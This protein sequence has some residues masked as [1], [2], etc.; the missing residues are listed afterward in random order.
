MVMERSTK[1]WR[2]IF[3]QAQR[4]AKK[5]AKIKKR[6]EQLNYNKHTFKILPNFIECYAR[7]RFNLTLKNA[8]GY[9]GVDKEG[10]RYQIKYTIKIKGKDGK[11]KFTHALDNIKPS[12]FDFLIAVI[13][14]EDYEIIE[15]YKIPKEFVKTYTTKEGSFRIT[16]KDVYDRLSKYK[17][18]I[19]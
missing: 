5:F 9:D 7:D 1:N 15:T 18:P 19:L 2:T 8:R 4:L 17:V 3:I 10:K 6:L 13:L 16:R 11:E 12:E 14:S